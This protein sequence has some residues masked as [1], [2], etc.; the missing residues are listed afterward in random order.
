MT[1]SSAFSVAAQD[2]AAIMGEPCALHINGHVLRE[3]ADGNPIHVLIREG[4]IDTRDVDV[5]PVEFIAAKIPKAD[6]SL[7][8]QMRD[9]IRIVINNANDSRGTAFQGG[10]YAGMTFNVDHVDTTLAEMYHFRV[11]SG[12]FHAGR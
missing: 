8:I 10:T 1:F 3:N 7:D 5:N 4:M 9:Q 2:I 11:T 12:E 6:V